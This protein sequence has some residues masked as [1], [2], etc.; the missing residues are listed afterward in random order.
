MKRVSFE[1]A[2]AIKEAGYP[3]TPAGSGYSTKEQWIDGVM[4]K[5][6]S[7]IDLDA[8]DVE[9]DNF[10]SIV[11]YL[12]VWLWLWREKKKW[13]EIVIDKSTNKAY[14]IINNHTDWIFDSND[15]PE[16]VIVA[17]IEYLCKNNLIE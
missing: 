9:S 14:P 16:E 8:F 10:V 13:I 1:V 12:D 5:E 7:Y 3:Q 15:N 6:G 17:A 4:F 2:K 11:S